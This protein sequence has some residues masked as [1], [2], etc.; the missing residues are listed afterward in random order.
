MGDFLH[1]PD[2]PLWQVY[3]A[4]RFGLILAMLNYA[5]GPLGEAARRCR[6]ANHHG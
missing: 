2:G 5:P 4:F 3:V 1:A 6:L